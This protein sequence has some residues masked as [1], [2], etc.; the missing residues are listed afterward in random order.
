MATNEERIEKAKEGVKDLI[1]NEGFRFE[2]FGDWWAKVGETTFWSCGKDYE[3]SVHGTSV[4]TTKGFANEIITLAEEILTLGSKIQ[5]NC[6]FKFVLKQGFV[7]ELMAGDVCNHTAPE[8]WNYSAERIWKRWITSKVQA[9][10][11]R[12]N[13]ENSVVSA[14]EQKIKARV[15]KVV[16]EQTRIINAK[17][18]A[19]ANRRKTVASLTK[20]VES[21]EA[22][23]ISRLDTIGEVT[24]TV[25]TDEELFGVEMVE[26]ADVNKVALEQSHISALRE[27]EKGTVMVNSALTTNEDALSSE[28]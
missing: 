25:G 24:E 7:I 10:V 13:D 19:I 14:S 22:L 18:R 5:A 21:K 23:I 6:P 20:I 9:Q 2:T 3:F 4:N 27:S 8:R 12:L 1:T 15:S 17:E 28:D 11:T 16:A 26:A